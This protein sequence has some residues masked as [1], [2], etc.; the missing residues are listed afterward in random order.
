MKI[1]SMAMKNILLPVIIII[2]LASVSSAQQKPAFSSQTYA[3]MVTGEA[4]TDLQ[5]QTINGLSWKQW[6]AGAG[7]G[8]DWYSFR[9]VPLFASVNRSFFQKGKR[10]LF[11]SGDAGVN[12]PWVEE[13]LYTLDLVYRDS[14]LS[15]GL[16]WAGGLGY[17]FGVG[18]AD[19]ALLF[20]VGYSYKR[21]QEKVTSNFPCFSPP[22]VPVT[23]TYDY[24]MKRISVRVGWGF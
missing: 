14:D 24:R 1:K 21:M 7:V 3:G 10:S 2:A 15:P 8:I 19:N 12:L 4:T 5:L 13:R 23:E 20:Q 17:R 11:V 18:K 16:Y 6:F 22:C 9:S